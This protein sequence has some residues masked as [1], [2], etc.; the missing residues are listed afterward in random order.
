MERARITQAPDL[1]HAILIGAFAG[2]NDAA[3]AATW[4]VKFLINQ[5]EA[6]AFA[7]IESDPFF[8]FTAR[9]PEVRI[10]NGAIRRISWPSNR[11]YVH[12]AARDE[13]PRRRDIVLLLGEEPH[14]NWKDFA[15][16]VVDVC[17][18]VNVEE[19]V[20][21]GSLVAEAPHTM[22]VPIQGTATASGILKRMQ[23]ADI[24]KSM[25]EGPT[26]ILAVVQDVARKAGIES[27]SLWGAAPHYV[28]ATPNLPVSQALLEKLDA[29]CSFDL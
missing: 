26:G 18:A 13:E 12:R 15:Q 22:P 17:R 11:F 28:S 14:Y 24:E 6:T 20:L 4:A 27:A 2:W 21:F 8:D 19:M 10:T 3:S 5:W 9:R 16:E 25:Y 29:L 7:E 23:R 1:E